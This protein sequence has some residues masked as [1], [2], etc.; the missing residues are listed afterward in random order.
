MKSGIRSQRSEVR[1]QR[2]EVI[3]C[4][5]RKGAIKFFSFY[6][7]NQYLYQLINKKL[8]MDKKAS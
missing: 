8:R 4:K 5:M 6:Q 2:S 1:G 3:S 7:T